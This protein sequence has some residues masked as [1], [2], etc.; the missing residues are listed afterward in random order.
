MGETRRT[1][2][3]G[4]ELVH[5]RAHALVVQRVRRRLRR[6]HVDLGELL[7]ELL[8]RHVASAVLDLVGDLRLEPV[9]HLPDVVALVQAHVPS[10]RADE[11]VSL[12]S[13]AREGDEAKR[14]RGRRRTHPS[15]QTGRVTP[16]RPA[17][18]GIAA[19][20]LLVVR[21]A[22]LGPAEIRVAPLLLRVERDLASLAQL[23]LGQLLPAH[24]V[25]ADEAH[26]ELVPPEDRHERVERLGSR[27]RV[28][29]EDVAQGLLERLGRVPAQVT[30]E[31]EELAQGEGVAKGAG[32][33]LL[34]QVLERRDER[35][36]HGDVEL[37]GELDEDAQLAGGIRVGDRAAGEHV[38]LS[39]R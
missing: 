20:V 35:L 21:L 18:P 15:A 6:R 28:E 4:D 25:H 14:E 16:A 34:A 13:R 22:V 8:A 7:G 24:R 3:E 11:V 12:S 38:Y 10:L 9:G 1:L 23:A 2:E 30:N 36:E 27:A 19:M 5:V 32:V 33:E 31:G 39:Q 17:R 37:W 26:A 29:V